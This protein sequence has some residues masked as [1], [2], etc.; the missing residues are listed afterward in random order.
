MA[1]MHQ[2]TSED[3]ELVREKLEEVFGVKFSLQ[4]KQQN[5]IYQHLSVIKLL[6]PPYSR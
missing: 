3:H 5:G 6:H 1:T 4:N 2:D